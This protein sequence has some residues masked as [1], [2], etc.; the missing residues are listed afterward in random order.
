MEAVDLLITVLS[1]GLGVAATILVSK[2]TN[3]ILTTNAAENARQNVEMSERLGEVE[4]AIREVA[5]GATIEATPTGV[6]VG[7]R[8][9]VLG[10]DG[11]MSAQVAADAASFLG[12]YRGPHR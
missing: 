5:L 2:K 8:E 10:T 1:F 6:K 7:G 3:A 11:R 9:I 4:A 12:G